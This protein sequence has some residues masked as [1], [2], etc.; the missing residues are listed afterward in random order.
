MNQNTTPDNQTIRLIDAF[1]Q[2]TIS[3]EQQQQLEQLL[4]ADPEQRQLYIDYM[5]VHNG[6]AS[7]ANETTASEDWI[8]QPP[9]DNP[10]SPLNTTRFLLILGSSLIAAT[11]LLSLAYYA[12]WNTRPDNLPS[13]ADTAPENQSNE[14][15]TPQTDHIALLTQAVGVEWDTSRNLQ[16]GAGLSAGWLKLKQ[17]TIQVELISG[18]SILIEGPAAVKLIS[19]LKAFCQYGKVRASVP[20]QAHGFTM[21][22]SRLN[23]VDLGT[24]FTLSLDQSGSGQVQ[25]IDGKVELHSPD[26]QS[27]Q[28]NIQSL[29]TGEGVQFNQR[30]TIDRL[31]KAMLPFIDSEELSQLVEQQQAQQ[32]KRWQEQNTMLK[33]DPSIIAYYDFEE[34]SNWL[35]TLNNKSQQKPSSSTNGAIVGCQWTSGRW[36]QKRSLEFKRTSDRV[37]THIPG[38]YQSL[39]FMAWVR[40]EGFDRWLS[41]LMLTD[42]YNPGN[43]HWQLSDKGEMILGVKT[44]PGK[45]YF[46][47]VVLQPTDLGR[48]IF[49]V[50]VYDHQKREVVHYLDG[51]AV[52]HH[53]IENPVPLVIGPAE[54]GNWR[55]QEHTG[56]HSIRSLN[57]RLDEFALFGRALPAEEILQLY[58]SGK[59]N[60]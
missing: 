43:P 58:Q 56:A 44:G 31:Q 55:P 30:G 19:P 4:A 51:V 27:T 23:V 53:K 52:S 11:L 29:T 37:R 12:G 34:S 54:I 36:P 20:E 59:P 21:E 18:A 8:P 39:T 7:W 41:S 33:A 17:G 24:E 28:A 14:I 22:T 50:T 60:S 48:W 35:R 6:L 13:I 40:I 57:G 9:T 16:A 3:D 47:P 5:H 46:S 1:L 49:L 15:S 10:P 32:F 26:S 2:G 38:E 42:G 45:N 25:V